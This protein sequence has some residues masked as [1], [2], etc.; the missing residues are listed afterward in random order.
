MYVIPAHL[1]QN[2]LSVRDAAD[3]Q[4]S[5]RLRLITPGPVG[6]SLIFRTLFGDPTLLDGRE[7]C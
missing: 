3:S 2:Q 4:R 1:A 5:F 6:R 7:T